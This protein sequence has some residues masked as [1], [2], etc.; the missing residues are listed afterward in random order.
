MRRLRKS[1]T[2]RAL[3]SAHPV[4]NE[5]VLLW[6][7]LGL[8]LTAVGLILRLRFQRRQQV[9]EEKLNQ[10]VANNV[11]IPPS[12]HPIINPDICIGSFSCLEACPEG[13][14]L[15]IVD[16][17]PK[18]VEPAHCIGHG[19]CAAECPVTAIRLVFGSSERGVDL[20]EVNEVFE[21]NRAGIHIVGE[22]GGMGLIKNAMTQGIQAADYLSKHLDPIRM[23][24]AVDV[25][26]VGS[27][28][29]GLATALGCRAAKLTFRVLEQG[30]LGGTVAQYP[31]QKVVMTETVNLPLFGKFGRSTLSKEELLEAWGDITRTAKIRVEEGVK[32]TGIEGQDNRFTVLTSAGPVFARKVVLATGRRGSPAKMNVPGED[33]PH[34]AYR[35]IDPQQYSGCRVLVVGGG[36]SALEAAIQLATQSD[37]HVSIA[38][39]G[40]AFSRARHANRTQIE[41]LSKEARVHALFNT[42]LKAIFPDSVELTRSGERDTLRVDYIIACLGGALPLELLKQCE[43]KLKRHFGTAAEDAGERNPTAKTGSAKKYRE[44]QRLKRLRWAMFAVGAAIVGGLTLKGYSYYVLSHA[45]RMRSPLHH[46]L[47]PA[48]AVGHGVGILATGVLMGNFLYAARKRWRPLRGFGNI[49]EWLS[50]HMG[51]GFIAPMVIAFHAAFQSNNQLATSTSAALAIVVS[52]GLV[53]RFFYNLAPTRDGRAVDRVDLERTWQGL[54]LQLAALTRGIQHTP[55]LDEMVTHVGSRPSAKSESFTGMVLT[56]PKQRLFARWQLM[57]SRHLFLNEQQFADFSQAFRATAKLRTQVAFYRGLK[58][59]FAVWRILHVGL[60]LFLMVMI[61]AHIG[62]SLYLGYSLNVFH[63]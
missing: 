41:K 8:V 50:V 9:G 24:T 42:E 17:K 32:V 7:T 54:Q 38:Y 20:P 10:A 25:A 27:G 52:T 22:L 56:V 47:R 18:L 39:R 2:L 3:G 19:K 26:I 60:S 15:G 30:T 31:R 40:K 43:I 28:P 61:A 23:V 57:R 62:V 46:L 44:I 16:S 33:L 55:D 51:I 59:W 34:V 45:Q 12:L 37:A 48:G 11:H 29:A 14:I 1:S 49:R 53:G 36:D 63:R 21:S 6:V 35:L 4:M 13:D 58:K 5:A